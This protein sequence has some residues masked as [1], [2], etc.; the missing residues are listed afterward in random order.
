M[1]D[2]GIGVSRVPAQVTI[3]DN[4]LTTQHTNYDEV[5]PGKHTT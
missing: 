2:T 3:S 1:E 5:E 4:E